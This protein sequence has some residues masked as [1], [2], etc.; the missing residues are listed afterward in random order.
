[1]AFNVPG[2]S[3]PVLVLLRRST[4]EDEAAIE[5]APGNAYQQ[6]YVY[7]DHKWNGPSPWA[8]AVLRMKYSLL[9]TF[10]RTDYATSDLVLQIE[11]PR[12]CPA[13]ESLD[14]RPAWTR[15]YLPSAEATAHNH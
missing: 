11:V 14:W 10:G 6:Q 4:F 5:S 2:C 15:T 3:Q 12:D 7:F 8:V 13:V 1:M 9:S